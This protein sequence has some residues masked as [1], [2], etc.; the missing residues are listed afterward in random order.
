MYGDRQQIFSRKED[1]RGEVATASKSPAIF[2]SW[3][4]FTPAQATRCFWSSHAR[5]SCEALAPD[6]G[7]LERDRRASC[8]TTF[9]GFSRR[10]KT[11]AIHSRIHSSRSSFHSIKYQRPRA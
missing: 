6:Q 8:L 1:L 7:H 4:M 11:A 10:F 9:L 2:G 5:Q 3:I